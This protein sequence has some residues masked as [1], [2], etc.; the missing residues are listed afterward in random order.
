MKFKW[1]VE[2]SVDEK[3]VADG[4]EMTNDVAFEMLSGHLGWANFDELKAKVVKYPSN[5]SIKKAQGYK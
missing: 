5:K 1:L 4:F 3:W 2:F